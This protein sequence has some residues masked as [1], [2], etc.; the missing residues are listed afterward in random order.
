MSRPY[1]T[2]S[3]G[4]GGSHGSRHSS[5]HPHL[6]ST[7][8]WPTVAGPRPKPGRLELVSQTT[9]IKTTKIKT[10]KH[11]AVPA[12][13]PA[14]RRA[15]P[16]DTR[17]RNGPSDHV[18]TSSRGSRN[19]Y[20]PRLMQPPVFPS[21]GPS[22]HGS[23]VSG[24]SGPGE[25]L[26]IEAPGAPSIAPSDRSGV[27]RASHYTDRP[28]P[29]AF[30]TNKSASPEYRRLLDTAPDSD[31]SISRVPS[32]HSSRHSSRRSSRAPSRSSAL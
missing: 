32:R 23:G 11:F 28:P 17:S 25:Q 9:T 1:S 18:S 4:S 29:T 8:G 13:E 12:A 15:P 7:S 27:T 30:S 6:P 26:Y 10:V 24:V 2:A 20:Q 19:S 14:A 21:S 16:T 22:H 5:S 3:G 31:S